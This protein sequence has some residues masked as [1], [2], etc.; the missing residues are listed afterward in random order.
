MPK[1]GKL[2]II[3]VIF[4]KF[5]RGIEGL[6]TNNQVYDVTDKVEK[7]VYSGVFKI[8]VNDSFLEGNEILTK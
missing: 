4:V 8:P 5:E 3:K 2:E 1:N 7:M 6:Q